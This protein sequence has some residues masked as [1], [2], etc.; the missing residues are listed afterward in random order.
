VLRALVATLLAVITLRAFMADEPPAIVTGQRESVVTASLT[1]PFV[2]RRS[3]TV[4]GSELPPISPPCRSSLR[5]PE[6][7]TGASTTPVSVGK[8]PI[9]CGCPRVVS[10][11]HPA[12][13]SGTKLARDLQLTGRCPI[14]VMWLQGRY[15]T[16]RGTVYIDDTTGTRGGVVS[17]YTV[18]T[19]TDAL[20]YRLLW[21]K[22]IGYLPKGRANFAVATTGA[23]YLA[24]WELCCTSQNTVVDFSATA[25]R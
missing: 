23:Q 8:L 25:H 14:A 19:P 16:V 1:Q 11:A 5:T 13:W 3:L 24:L 6:M 9:A 21:S 18:E 4:H 7:R 10:V 22:N 17:I 12:S 2:Y 20:T 15:A